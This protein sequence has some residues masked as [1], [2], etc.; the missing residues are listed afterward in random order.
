MVTDV[1]VLKGDV[2]EVQ[3]LIARQPTWHWSVLPIRGASLAI[4]YSDTPHNLEGP[5]PDSLGLNVK[6][7]GESIEIIRGPFA[8]VPTYWSSGRLTWISTAPNTLGDLIPQIPCLFRERSW[9]NTPRLVD[10]VSDFSR[11]VFR[12]PPST[13]LVIDTFG[14]SLS[15]IVK[16]TLNRFEPDE[17]EV[18]SKE[19]LDAFMKSLET[20]PRDAAVALSGGLD[21]SAILA[22]L[23]ALGRRPKTFTMKSKHPISDER[24]WVDR[25]TRFFGLPKAAAIDIDAFPPFMSGIPFLEGPQSQPT[26]PFETA[27]YLRASQEQPILTGLGADQLFDVPPQHRLVSAWKYNDY[28]AWSAEENQQTSIRALKT[29]WGGDTLRADVFSSWAWEVS[30]RG[31]RRISRQLSF[32]IYAPFLQK[33]LCEITQAMPAHWRHQGT[34]NKYILRHALR[35]LLPKDVQNR[36]K[37]SHFGPVVG[38]SFLNSSKAPYSVESLD[39][40]LPIVVPLEWRR[41]ALARWKI[42]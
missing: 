3:R 11:G 17:L 28:L 1:T 22:G 36:P 26:E 30:M 15:P 9:Q 29:L 35:N 19:L 39:P 4:G 32:P 40:R 27:F 42:K 5:T 31:L 12:L 37:T 16:E 38:H 21:S 13:K 25:L 33:P 41:I 24:Q 8:W 6:V 18:A 20:M 10:G 34:S 2:R 14:L 7:S 23:V